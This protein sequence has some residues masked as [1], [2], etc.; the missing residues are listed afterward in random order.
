MKCCIAVL[1]ACGL[2]LSP[3]PG[4][5]K[6]AG[7]A[8]KPPL[9]YEVRGNELFAVGPKGTPAVALTSLVPVQ[10]ADLRFAALRGEHV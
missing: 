2:L 7:K 1:L 8:E 5:A 3:P 9:T 4:E 10:G 6:T